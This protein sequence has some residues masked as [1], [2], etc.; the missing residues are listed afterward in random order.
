MDTGLYIVGTPIGN[1]ADITY[2]AVDT[3]KQV[4]VI[5]AEDTRH[6]RRLLNHYEIS[7]PLKSCHH[8]NEAKRS[9]DVLRCLER[10]EAIALISDAGMPCVSDPG[11]RVVAACRAVGFP[12]VV[13]PGPSAV[14]SAFALSGMMD[15]TFFFEGFLPRK[16]GKRAKR[17]ELI[18]PRECPTLIYEAPHRL[19]K[20]MDELDVSV[21]ATCAVVVCRELTKKFEET[22]VGTPQNIRDQFA[23]RSVKGELVVVVRGVD[24]VVEKRRKAPGYIKE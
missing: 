19:L 20:L 16:S 13:I 18:V 12:V 24:V 15:K 14:V 21:G 17:L 1:L 6:S 8:F 11:S 3:L 9:E 5:M 2:R 10:G 4:D 7:T 22:L 23:Q